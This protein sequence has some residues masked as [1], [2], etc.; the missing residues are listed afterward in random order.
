MTD[1]VR[2][3]NNVHS[4]N[5]CSWKFDLVP[6]DG[7]NAFDFDEKRERKIVYAAK[8]SGTPLGWT[9]G[10]YSV[11][12]VR[13]VM[14]RESATRLLQQMTLKGL[15]SYGDAEFNITLSIAE[16]LKLPITHVFDPCC[17]V[18]KKNTTAEGVEELLTEFEIACL[19]ITENGMRLW[20]VLRELPL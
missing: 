11:P 5:S 14:V 15:G 8:K 16:P 19:K 4:H 1:L 9:A 2:I 17:I 18:G 3:G 6:Y 12:P 10:K 7:I 20:S 13:L